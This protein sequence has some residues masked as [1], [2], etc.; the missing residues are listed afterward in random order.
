MV[1]LPWFTN[2]TVQMAAE[3]VRKTR[4]RITHKIDS[5]QLAKDLNFVFY[6]H[7][8][9]IS[10]DVRSRA[11]SI[12]KLKLITSKAKSLNNALKDAED[13]FIYLGHAAGSLPEIRD[14]YKDLV[15]DLYPWLDP[16]EEWGVAAPDAVRTAFK[17]VEYL[18]E[19]GE[20]A[21]RRGPP[22]K[23]NLSPVADL[24]GIAL[25]KVYQDHF[26]LPF[27]AGTAGDRQS[28]GPGIRFVLASLEAGSIR[29][30]AGKSYSAETVRTYWQ[31]VQSGKRRRSLGQN[32]QK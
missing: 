3:I 22:K 8:A 29:P 14:T 32:A 25:P 24:V 4:V 1:K 21:I 15:P 28:S 26:W 31:N 10:R 30:L 13:V 18:V 20:H 17:G 7:M 16:Q 2:V 12:R 5:E 19:W 6:V 27:G 23:H 9:D 11:H